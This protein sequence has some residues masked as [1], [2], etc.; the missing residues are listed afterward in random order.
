MVSKHKITPV[1]IQPPI[2]GKSKIH[3]GQMPP[4]QP[5][6]MPTAGY[7][8]PNNAL[9][10]P[11]TM[12]GNPFAPSPASA[13][14]MAPGVEIMPGGL[15]LPPPPP[16]PPPGWKPSKKKRKN[17]QGV[18]QRHV[19]RVSNS[20]LS[21]SELSPYYSGSSE[22]DDD[23][24]EST[25]ESKKKRKEEEENEEKNKQ[26]GRNEDLTALEELEC[27]LAV[28]RVKG[29]DLSAKEWCTYN[30]RFSI[31]DDLLRSLL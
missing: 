1:P 9:S 7:Y 17:P 23:F 28:P 22:V 20:S 10:L 5:M 15:G 6:H 31:F 4:G 16:P 14:S 13:S 11:D 21:P 2:R 29:F 27:I 25:L 24:E 30:Y 19:R 18:S 8:H 3:P 26:G 12:G